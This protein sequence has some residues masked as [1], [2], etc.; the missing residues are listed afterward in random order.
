[1]AGGFQGSWT[2]RA[3]AGALVVALGA[4]GVAAQAPAVGGIDPMDVTGRVIVDGSSTVWPILAEAAER[5]TA[6]GGDVR[7]DL[8][9]SGT[10]GG[11]RRFCAGESD[12]ANASRPINEKEQAACAAAGVTPVQFEVGLDGITVVVNPDN[13]AVACLTVEQLRELWRPDSTVSAW[14]DLDPSWPEEPIDLF[15]PGPDSGTFDFFTEAIVGETDLSRIDY[16]PSENDFFLVEE[17]ALRPGALGYFG[18]AYAEE[19]SGRLKEVAVDN[20][21]GCIPPSAATIADGSY[22]PLTRPLFIY[23]NANAPRPEVV[24]FLRFM[25]SEGHSIVEAAGYVPLP[26]AA[27]AAM[28]GRLL[29]LADNASVNSGTPEAR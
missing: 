14:S 27:Y 19:A 8:E 23:A 6:A 28:S 2:I 26:D 24:S 20:G 29:D 25:A 18:F 17:V 4:G 22:A 9:V 16:T 3:C 5:F 1:M 13:A 21:A 11:F 15:G 12:I 10:S 7:F